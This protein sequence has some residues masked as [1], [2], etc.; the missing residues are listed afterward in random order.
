MDQVL[1]GLSFVYVYIDDVLIASAIPEE[2]FEHLRLV[3]ELLATHGLAS[4]PI[5][6]TSV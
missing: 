5:G 6:A 3:F 1:F 2:H 4:T